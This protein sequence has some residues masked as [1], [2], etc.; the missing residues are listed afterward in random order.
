MCVENLRSY[1]SDLLSY[2]S[3]LLTISLG[4]EVR[5]QFGPDLY[6][7]IV[8]L[9]LRR[10]SATQIEVSVKSSLIFMNAPMMNHSIFNRRSY[11]YLKNT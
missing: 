6:S 7:A 2:S 4:S 1:S 9:R 10:I 5:I 3:G 8:P 11:L